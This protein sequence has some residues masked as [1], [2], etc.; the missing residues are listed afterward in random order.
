MSGHFLKP[1]QPLKNMLIKRAFGKLNNTFWTNFIN[2]Y[3]NDKA[4]NIL[5]ITRLLT[6]KIAKYTSKIPC[7]GIILLYT[8]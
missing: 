5:F 1:Y 6:K 2:V 4:C 3:W 7:N 8:V